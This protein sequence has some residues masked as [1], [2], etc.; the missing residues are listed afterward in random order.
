M[1][2]V[3]LH[4]VKVRLTF[5]SVMSEIPFTVDCP[6]VTAASYRARYFVVPA[7][8]ERVANVLWW[9]VRRSGG[10]RPAVPP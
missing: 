9:A 2:E 4:Y 7:C 8:E 1:T 10:Q 3:I 6:C 5:I